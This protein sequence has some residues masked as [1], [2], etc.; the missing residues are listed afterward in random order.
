MNEADAR[1]P[2]YALLVDRSFVAAMELLS[3]FTVRISKQ[4]FDHT[5]YVLMQS[6]PVTLKIPS[7]ED[8]VQPRSHASLRRVMFED[9][10]G[11]SE[12]LECRS[13]RCNWSLWES[14]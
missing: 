10:T 13:R 12:V 8:M 7:R 1:R 5:G 6:L 11:G 2:K 9:W 4:H 14:G 3:I